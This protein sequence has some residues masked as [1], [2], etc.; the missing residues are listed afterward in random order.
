MDQRA[1]AEEQYQQGLDYVHSTQGER[2]ENLQR[3]IA[4]YKMALQHYTPEAF[5]E[6]WE[7]IQQDLAAAYSELVQA[8]LKQTQ[9]IPLPSRLTRRLRI[10]LQQSLL[11]ALAIMVILAISA[12]TIVT[13]YLAHRGP[14]CV[15]GALN[16]DGSTVLQPLVQAVAEDYMLHCSGALITIGGG[17]S[18]TG[19][20][21]VEQGH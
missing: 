20:A 6:R 7:Q 5:P 3:A 17:A 14:S 16:V 1:V 13:T 11:L 12:A 9:E 8:R 10:T 21:D 4:C 19:L 2:R 15:N 18:K